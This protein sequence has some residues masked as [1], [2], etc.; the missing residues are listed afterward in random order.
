MDPSSFTCSR[1][2]SKLETIYRALRSNYT[3][4]DSNYTRSGQL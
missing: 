1:D 3:K 2:A 4:P